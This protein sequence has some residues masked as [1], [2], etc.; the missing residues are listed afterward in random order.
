MAK[1]VC[2]RVTG[3]VIV[4]IDETDEDIDIETAIEKANDAVSDMDFGELEDIDWK[5]SN[6]EDEDGNRIYED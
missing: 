2:V 6:I 3:T 5:T 1:F 4:E